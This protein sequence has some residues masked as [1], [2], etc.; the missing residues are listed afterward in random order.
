MREIL[1]RGL[2]VE[3]KKW[4]YGVPIFSGDEAGI[5]QHSGQNDAL[6]ITI[7]GVIPET[8]GQF[9]ELLD[10][11]GNKVFEGDIFEFELCIIRGEIK[12]IRG[13]VFWGICNI[14]G[15]EEINSFVLKESK[16]DKCGDTL[17]LGEKYKIVG[18]IHENPELLTNG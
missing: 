8:V 17:D 3:T 2:C 9:T 18:N 14:D 5:V 4:V 16:Q 1:F 13:C 11:E 12:K 10:I 6:E 7:I 15:W